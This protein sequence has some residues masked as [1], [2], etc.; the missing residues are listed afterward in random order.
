MS[1]TESSGTP[2][3]A[4]IGMACRFPGA[5]DVDAF[6]RNLR[7]GVESITFFSDA[8]LLAAGVDPALLRDP[9]YVRAGAVLTDIEHFDAA[10]FGFT[11]RDAQLLDPQQRLFLEC[12]WEA[13]EHAGYPPGAHPGPIGVYAG[14]GLNL[15][16]L[17][18]LHPNRSLI[19]DVGA[20]RVFITND[21]D[22]VPTRVAYKLNLRG[23]AVN[24]QTACSTSL[25]AVHL[26]CQGLLGGE[27][28]LALAGG[29][30]IRLPQR[31]G[32]LHQAGLFFSHDGHTRAFDARASGT[33]FMSGAGLVVLKRLEEALADRDPIYAVIKGSA[34]NN[35]GNLKMDFTAPS[36]GGQA[37]VIGEALAVAGVPAET[38][39]YVETH[40]AATAMGDPI[41]VAA[42]TESFRTSTAK[43]GYCAIGS[44]KTNV[45]HLDTAAGVAGLIKTALALHHKQIPPSLNFESPNPEIDFPHSPFYVN[46]RLAD[47]E[48]RDFPRRAGVSA[49]GIGGTN[50]HVVLEEAPQ[51]EAA[52]ATPEPPYHLLTLSAK[53]EAALRATAERFEHWLQGPPRAG[54]GDVCFTSHAGRTH[55]EHRLAIA[56]ASAEDAREQLADSIAGREGSIARGQA[57]SGRRPQI[58]FLFTGQGAEYEQMG[59][60]LYETQPVFRHALDR[61]AE[62]LKPELDRPLLDVIFPA[63]GVE[64][65][66]HQTAYTQPALF[67][68]E[69]ALAS[70]WQDWGVR[71]DFVMGHSAGE[72]VAAC[73]A[74]VFSLEDGLRLI[75]ARGRLMQALPAEGR[76]VAVQ[77]GEARAAAAIAPYAK[78]VSLAALNGPANTVISGRRGAV[79]AVCA[80]L[81]A[82][83]VKATPLAISVAAHSPLVEPMLDEFAR[84]ARTVTFAP[85]RVRLI[86]NVSGGAES[87]AVATP[88]YWVRHVRNPVRF[89]EGMQTLQSQ[90]C[91]A[92]IE[93]GAKPVLLGMGRQSVT[94]PA[95][96]LPSLRSGH[97][98]RQVMLRSL[99]ELYVRGVEIDWH[100]FHRDTGRRRVALPTYPFQRQRYWVDP[101]AEA[102]SSTSAVWPGQR[103]R[104]PFSSEMRFESRFS[105]AWPAHLTD[106]RLA[107]TVVVAA[108]THLAWVIDAVKAAFDTAAVT[109]EEIVCPQALVLLDGAARTLQLILTPHSGDELAFRIVSLP[110]DRADGDSSAWITH[111]TG[112]ARLGA[113][114]AE[115]R[116][117]DPS[118]I[119]AR[120][121]RTVAESEFYTSLRRIGYDTGPTFQCIAQLWRGDGE[122]I[123]QMRL[124]VVSESRDEFVLHPGL[125][126]SCFQVLGGCWPFEDQVEGSNEHFVP[127]RIGRFQV[128]ASPA[129]PDLWCQARLRERDETRLAGDLRLFDGAG[130]TIAAITDFESRR[131]KHAALI[132]PHATP[133]DEWLYEIVWEP[134]AS[135]A[136]VALTGTSSWLILADNG[137]VGTSLAEQLGRHGQRCVIAR[138]GT[139]FKMEASGLYRL[140]P[141]APEHFRRLWQEAFGPEQPPLRGVVHLWS[142]DQGDEG[143]TLTCGSVLHLIQSLPS[144]ATPTPGLWLV[145]CGAQPADPAGAPANPAQATMWGLGRTLALEHSELNCVLL[146]LDPATDVGDDRVLFEAV[147][148]PDAET[149]VAFRQGQRRAAR[150]S[151]GRASARREAPAFSAQATCLITGGLGGLG[152]AVARWM[153]A[154][155]AR[156]LALLGRKGPDEAAAA[157]LAEFQQ[158]GAEVRVF[159]ADV[160]DA[161]ALDRALTEVAANLPPVR[162]VIHAAGVLDDGLLLHQTWAQF[163]RV[164]APKFAGA[165]NLHRLTRHWPLE[166]FVMFSS[167]ASVLGAPGQG[168]YAAANAYLDALAGWRR[169]QGLPALSLNWGPW[170]DLGLAARQVDGRP[171]ENWGLDS[172]SPA[173]ALRSLETLLASDRSAIAILPIQWPKFLRQFRAEAR[174]PF[175]ERF[176]TVAAAPAAGPS[177]FM[178]RLQAA[179]G[180]DRPALL[181]AHLREQ[182]AGVLGLPSGMPIEKRQRLFDMGLESLTALD[183]KARLEKSLGTSLRST[184]IFDYP[185]LEALS[186][187]LG[188]EVL[189][190]DAAPLPVPAEMAAG[191]DPLAGLSTEEVARRLA[192]ELE[193]LQRRKQQ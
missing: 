173:Q 125:I 65:P 149:Q 91:E 112:R 134:A 17:Q 147:S 186:D 94:G 109:L 40:G 128:H 18:H 88:D 189:K 33:V 83:G 10:F 8:E 152:L 3:V 63:A 68:L 16:L 5:P 77:T 137:A 111:M 97:P 37:A 30:S 78:E 82:D 166:F 71:P 181:L 80:A 2:A 138:P 76:M 193:S 87:R 32:Y 182:V 178:R 6:W 44:V 19:E 70:L 126:D 52:P 102:A 15:Y 133:E 86:S 26:A 118:A 72:Y 114:A 98:D 175:F 21:K 59:R 144:A 56:A 184:L 48:A 188:R 143:A 54:F 136:E 190:L 160:A 155:G 69:F 177:E 191:A 119:Q 123:G 79:E 159:T 163:D 92:Y 148:S 55:F 158:A 117:D 121:G 95:A 93:I 67:A 81:E 53:S 73:V 31:V 122:A 174:P 9:R 110:P 46:A 165:L 139:Q 74:G 162:G 90:G 156:H 58:G 35:D 22:F 14:A 39:A 50:A 161:N 41:E 108:A 42:L 34:I 146:D 192:E 113:G 62:L 84:F 61:C 116:A 13:L 66:I 49:F 131:V 85:P 153:I 168:N 23:P 101:P 99:G 170:A 141:L 150:L 172:I 100:A 89:A 187:H 154:H 45:G 75:A 171:F 20:W 183:L 12:A 180:R 7:A 38:I 151:R 164:L 11:P 179:P 36:V 105:P 140:D 104:L 167:A 169:A 28:D 185:T 115:A 145:T 29:V 142:L 176:V 24:V 43:R 25:V 157:T 130:R 135:P 120:C 47:W 27:C 129:E 51:P 1:P 60:Q 96:W 64:S 124:P 103:L 107:G 4:I 132:G 106:H 127:F 57:A